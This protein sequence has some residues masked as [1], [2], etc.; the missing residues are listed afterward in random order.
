MT[1]REKVIE[2]LEKAKGFFEARAYM[3]VGNGKMVLLE[4]ANAQA[5]AIK[6]LKAQEPVKPVVKDAW[7]RPIYVCGVCGFRILKMDP[8]RENYCAQ[9][10]QAIMW[11][12]PKEG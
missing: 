11:E 2:G 4:W 12:P 8:Y 7:P 3:A 1:D 10:G 9:C 5:D 6:L